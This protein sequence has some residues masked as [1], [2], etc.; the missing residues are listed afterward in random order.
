[1]IRAAL[2]ERTAAKH[3][4]EVSAFCSFDGRRF[5]PKSDEI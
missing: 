4:S 1:M 3:W 2:L 5:K